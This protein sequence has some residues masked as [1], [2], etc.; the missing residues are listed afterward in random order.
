MSS[1]KPSSSYYPISVCQ[2]TYLCFYYLLD[3]WPPTALF[4]VF[5]FLVNFQDRSKFTCGTVTSFAV[6][7]RINFPTLFNIIFFVPLCSIWA[8]FITTLRRGYSNYV[9]LKIVASFIGNA[10]SLSSPLRLPI[11]FQF[12]SC[13]FH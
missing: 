6:H 9:I 7:W 1:I 12:K 4:I 8:F 11:K 10:L 3:Y 5:S 13:L 2:W